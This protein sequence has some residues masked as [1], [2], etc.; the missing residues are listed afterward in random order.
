MRKICSANPDWKIRFIFFSFNNHKY[1]NGP[2]E[3]TMVL[4]FE[5]A[6][7]FGDCTCSINRQQRLV[8]F[9]SMPNLRSQNEV[10]ISKL[11]IETA[12]CSF[13]SSSSLH[14]SSSLLLHRSPLLPLSSPLSTTPPLSP[15][16]LLS[17][18]TA[19]LLSHFP[20][21]LSIPPLLSPIFPPPGTGIALS[22]A[23][24]PSKLYKGL[25]SQL[26]Q[27]CR[28]NVRSTLTWVSWSLF[29]YFIRG[30][31]FLLHVIVLTITR[32]TLNAEK[33]LAA[34]EP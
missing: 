8:P 14:L 23:N 21:P 6:A 25:I 1:S 9:H 28:I 4:G 15:T 5:I 30:G 7:N 33:P 2:S 19:F 29:L 26:T 24:L 12:W 34:L 13:L 32:Q 27:K 11:W 3:T 18:S 22:S 16:A 20:P 31:N 17:S 10:M